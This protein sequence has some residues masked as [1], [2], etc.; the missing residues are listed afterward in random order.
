M[1]GKG[2]EAA[3]LSD[4][5][6]QCNREREEYYRREREKIE[7]R[8]MKD[9]KIVSVYLDPNT[10]QEGLVKV[11]LYPFGI[12]EEF[13]EDIHEGKHPEREYYVL[14]V[15]YQGIWY[16]CHPKFKGVYPVRFDT[17]YTTAQLK[18]GA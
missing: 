18:G 12:K 3:L 10:T 14:Y 4:F 5:R 9:G 6:D 7:E 16:D 17:Y 1:K 11:D 13:A 15:L 2:Y 8:K